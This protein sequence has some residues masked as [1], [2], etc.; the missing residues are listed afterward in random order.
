MKK[1][2]K[3]SFKVIIAIDRKSL[4]TDIDSHWYPLIKNLLNGSEEAAGMPL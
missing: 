1:Y 2:K 3:T 4:E